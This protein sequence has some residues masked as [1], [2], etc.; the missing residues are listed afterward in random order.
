MHREQGRPLADS[1]VGFVQRCSA[2]PWGPR[3]WGLIDMPLPHRALLRGRDWTV[4]PWPALWAL[5]WAQH[6]RPGSGEAE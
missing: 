5:H 1:R 2:A 6:L 4:L 3:T